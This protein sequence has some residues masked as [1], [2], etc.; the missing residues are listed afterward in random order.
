ME[1]INLRAG[2]LF[3]VV[4]GICIQTMWVPKID[5][6][7][8]KN[9]LLRYRYMACMSEMKLLKQREK[10][11][12]RFSERLDF[13]VPSLGYS[14]LQSRILNYPWAIRRVVITREDPFYAVTIFGKRS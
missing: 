11:R 6:I 1:K 14:H 10:R 13:R 7:L 9:F 8:E 3:L 2:I 12:D 4:A 5:Q